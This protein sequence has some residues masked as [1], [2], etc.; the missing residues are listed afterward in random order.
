MKTLPTLALC[1]A[2]PLAALAQPFSPIYRGFF[3]TNPNPNI[4]CGDAT[5]TIGVVSNPTTGT[6]SMRV[7]S[8]PF[9]FESPTV[10]YLP[11]FTDVLGTTYVEGGS[12]YESNGSAIFPSPALSTSP[13]TNSP[14]NEELATAG[15]VRGLIAG[16]GIEIF[17][18]TNAST[19][20]TNVGSGQRLYTFQTGIPAPANVTFAS[21]TNGEY[22]G[23]TVTTNTFQIFAG[24]VVGNSYIFFPSGGGR[25]V[26][27]HEE[28][29]YSYDR[30]NW[31]ELSTTADQA[32]IG[33][34]TNLYQFALAFPPYVSTN[35][36]GFYVQKRRKVG[37]QTATPNVTIW[38]GTNTP[39]HMDIAGPNSI[40]GN[41]FLGANQ[42]WTGINTYT[43][44]IVVPNVTSTLV[45]SND[46]AGA[47]SNLVVKMDVNGLRVIVTNNL[48]L[49]NWT[50]L[51]VGTI[52]KKTIYLVV[53]N[54]GPWSILYPTDGASFGLYWRT[55]FP[56]QANRPY[57]SLTN[58][59]TY[60]LS[61]QSD[62]TNVCASMTQW[63][64]P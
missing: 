3:T 28:V 63:S 61:A 14:A 30:T 27:I 41:S 13:S 43:Q 15:W 6:Y 39:S 57:T 46:L 58:G 51:A 11:V 40:A 31:T 7:L 38:V 54:G 34:S 18:T 53:T 37:V 29:Y 56:P 45:V 22:L 32:I 44:P 23:S 2:L 20:G 48:T 16:Q 25:S 55:N 33:G 35:T 9:T 12:F 1:A 19:V 50:Q 24:P 8:L 26:S 60:V 52:K 42:T 36:A 62:D 21:V 17:N 10:H 47:S 5:P 49:T 59:N 4:I 64:Y